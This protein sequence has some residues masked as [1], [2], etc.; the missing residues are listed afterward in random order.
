MTNIEPEN[1][2]RTDT[3]PL[4][5]DLFC[6]SC[7]YN[8]RGLS[9]D[10][11][12]CPECG[13][14][15][16]LGDAEIPAAMVAARLRRMETAPCVC[17][18][19]AL[20]G[21]CFSLP[22]V[23]LPLHPD[24]AV[25]VGVFELLMLGGWI[26]GVAGFRRSCAGKPGWLS[27]LGLYHLIG[28]TVAACM[29]ALLLFFSWRAIFLGLDG[30]WFLI[31]LGACALATLAVCSAMRPVHRLLTRRMHVLQREVAVTLLRE[32]SRRRVSRQWRRAWARMRH[33]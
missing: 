7:A 9:G 27:I 15:N 17:V 11:V 21:V 30:L 12:R 24:L 31:L 1:D 10:P 28:F 3:P 5:H 2:A 6:L 18:A 29:V 14:L 33:P 22:L 19:A 23:L 4:D 16:P 20:L 32:E 8:L 13:D 26:V 25:C